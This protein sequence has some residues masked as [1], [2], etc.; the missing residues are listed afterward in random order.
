MG[1]KICL[2]ASRFICQIMRI[3]AHFSNENIRKL[4]NFA[5]KKS[6]IRIKARKY[7]AKNKIIANWIVIGDIL[8]RA[9]NKL[10]Y[11]FVRSD[12]NMNSK[13]FVKFLMLGL[14][15]FLTGCIGYHDLIPPEF[16]QHKH[17]SKGWDQA[18]TYAKTNLKSIKIYDEFQTV[19]LFD[20]LRYSDEIAL[21]SACIKS[22]RKGAN[23]KIRG[24]I[25]MHELA[26]NQNEF[27]FLIQADVRKSCQ[28]FLDK[29]NSAWSF[30]L[31][32]EDGRKIKPSSI[33]KIEHTDISRQLFG[34]TYS[35]FKTLYKIVFPLS[36]NTLEQARS[37]RGPVTIVCRSNEHKC[38]VSWPAEF[39]WEKID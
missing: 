34:E 39:G 32:T 38:Q 21:S 14:T 20:F 11:K 7:L 2:E 1:K 24:Q 29:K 22:D 25:M 36:G 19:A 6:K 17:K 23:K 4:P 10:F 12:K 16:P 8:S 33:K 37:R 26:A 18:K 31:E 9:T 15:L 5:A 28:E 13:I 3:I 30:W 35:R 27:K